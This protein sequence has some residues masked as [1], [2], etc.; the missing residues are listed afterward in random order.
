MTSLLSPGDLEVV[1]ETLQ[2]IRDMP[3]PRDNHATGCLMSIGGLVVLLGLPALGRVITI[4]QG[5][6]TAGLLI[7]GALLV[8]GIIAWMTAGNW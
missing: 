3:P 6:G 2:E 5:L 1:H 4:G 8:L 7:G